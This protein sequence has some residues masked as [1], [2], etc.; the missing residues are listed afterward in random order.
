[1]NTNDTKL[2]VQTI[3]ST[4]LA[5]VTGGGAIGW[6]VKGV[7]KLGPKAVEAAKWTGIPSA[8]GA[9]AAWVKHQIDKQ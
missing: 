5:N 8:V 4:Q 3:D 2:Q 7:K 6:V 1:M 9:G